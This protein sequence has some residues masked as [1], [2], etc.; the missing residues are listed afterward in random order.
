MRAEI[1]L[2]GL[3]SRRFGG[4]TTIGLGNR[5]DAGDKQKRGPCRSV[6]PTMKGT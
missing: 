4:C 6:F 5:A 2:E 1:G 3:Q